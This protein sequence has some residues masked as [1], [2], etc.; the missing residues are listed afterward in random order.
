MRLT[1]EVLHI[2]SVLTFCLFLSFLFHSSHYDGFTDYFLLYYFSSSKGQLLLVTFSF[3]SVV[4]CVSH[5]PLFWLLVV[6]NYVFGIIEL[7]IFAKEQL[8]I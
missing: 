6:C 4:P 8:K 2:F 7:R 5:V 3:M 1:S